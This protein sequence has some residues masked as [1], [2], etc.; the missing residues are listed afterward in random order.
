MS[1]VE[2]VVENN[3][4]AAHPNFGL[5]SRNNGLVV[6]PRVHPPSLVTAI[7][8]NPRHATRE[9]SVFMQKREAPLTQRHERHVICR[10]ASANRSWR[11]GVATSCRP[12]GFGDLGIR[13]SGYHQKGRITE[14][15]YLNF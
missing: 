6:A 8:F 3:C 5:T 10:S 11:S 13:H 9:S 7:S 4:P 14:Q 12:L 2:H 15:V 1:T